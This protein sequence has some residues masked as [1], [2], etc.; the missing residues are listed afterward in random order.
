MGAHMLLRGTG[1]HPLGALNNLTSSVKVEGACC[2]A[3]GY[4][5]TDC[6]GTEGNPIKSTMQL[7]PGLPAGVVTPA[8]GIASVWG[9]NDC[10]QCVKITQELDSSCM[11]SAPTPNPTTNSPTQANCF[12]QANFVNFDWGSNN[13][14]SNQPCSHYNTKD[15]YYAYC[16]KMACANTQRDA[17]CAAGG[18]G[19]C[20]NE[21]GRCSAAEQADCL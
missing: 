4:T 21:C 11:T 16:K 12:G 3:Y 15:P 19:A 2:A 7:L 14:C 17:W 13:T 5:S 1:Y 8:T 20:R 18:S 6:S 10:V 9:C